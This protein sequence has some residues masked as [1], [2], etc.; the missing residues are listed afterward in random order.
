MYSSNESISKRIN[1]IMFDLGINQQQLAKILNIT[2]PAVSK[3]LKGRIP[4]PNILLQLSKLSGMTIEWILTGN[5]EVPLRSDMVSDQ[6]EQ[7]YIKKTIEEKFNM[8]P[9][10][11]QNNIETLIDSI[12]NIR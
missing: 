6:S 10:R 5:T 12:L 11:I 9:N 1:K 7:Y 2:Q 4:P 3:Y 8:L